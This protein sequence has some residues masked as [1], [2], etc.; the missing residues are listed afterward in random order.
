MPEDLPP[1]FVMS[2][3]HADGAGGS[4]L[5]RLLAGDTQPLP[6]WPVVSAVAQC[7]LLTLCRALVRYG[8]HMASAAIAG[9][10][11]AAWVYT[12]LAPANVVVTRP[13]AL[14]RVLEGV[15]RAV[16]WSG[17]RW[18]SWPAVSV[19]VCTCTASAALAWRSLPLALAVA[20]APVLA[21]GLV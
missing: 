13:A 5:G 4:H 12:E 3:A 10:F 17:K 19:C 15:G 14:V 1:S 9:V 18:R 2:A 21:C 6:V 7:V 20:V 11:G 8:P 16:R